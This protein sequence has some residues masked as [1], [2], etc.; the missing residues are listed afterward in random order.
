MK[1]AVCRFIAFLL[2]AI[3]LVVTSG[4]GII[5]IQTAMM[6]PTEEVK[7]NR[8]DA[9][10]KTV[11][12]FVNKYGIVTEEEIQPFKDGNYGY[13]D[14]D[15]ADFHKDISGVMD[16]VTVDITG[17][18]ENE[19]F[20]VWYDEGVRASV[21]EYKNGK[22]VPVWT[23]NVG[24]IFTIF[25]L[26]VYKK[27]DKVLWS[28]GVT[29]HYIDDMVS[30]VDGEYKGAFENGYD[31][32]EDERDYINEK[33]MNFGLMG[34]GEA[35]IEVAS[36]RLGVTYNDDSVP[37]LYFSFEGFD[38]PATPNDFATRWGIKIPKPKVTARELL[39]KLPYF[40]DRSKCK[41]SKEMA[42][43]YAKTISD[44]KNKYDEASDYAFY[45]Y[46]ADPAGDGM[47]ILITAF[48]KIDTY[49]GMVVAYSGAEQ[50]MFDVW[51][52]DGKKVNN[53]D[54]EKHNALG[55][56]ACGIE[57]STN[58][59]KPVVSLHFN[60][61]SGTDEGVRGN[62]YYS[63]ENGKMSVLHTEI[64]CAA[65]GYG[66]DTMYGYYIPL[67]DGSVYGEMVGKNDGIP[68]ET[69]IAN[70][71]TVSGAG[72][73]G[74]SAVGS[75]WLVDGKLAKTTE[76]PEGRNLISDPHSQIMGGYP[77]YQLY[78]WVDANITAELLAEYSSVAGRPSYSYAEA[79]HMISDEQI[80]ALAEE[81]AKSL[82]GEIGD[83]YKLADDLYYIVIYVGGKPCGG[84]VVKNTE[85]GTGWRTIK[86]SETVLTEAELQ[87][88]VNDEQ[89]VSNVT[90]DF[91][92]TE[93]GVEQLKNVFANIDGTVPNDAAKSDISSY[94]EACISSGS[95]VSVKT[96]GNGAEITKAVFDECRKKAEDKRKELI[97]VV[98][99]NGVSL[100]KEIT[101]IIRIVCLD[102][103][104]KNPAKI[105]LDSDIL[106]SIGDVDSVKLIIGDE[107]HAITISVDTLRRYFADYGKKL[108]ITIEKISN[109]TYSVSFSDVTGNFLQ[110]L[111]GGIT[112]T[113][114]ADNEFCTVLAEYS[115]ETR[116]WGGQFDETNNTISFETPYPGKYSVVEG[117]SQISDIDGLPAEK[118]K[119]IRFMVSKGY[120]EAENKLFNP[121]ATLT[122]YDFAMALVRMFF[123]LDTTLTCGFSDVPAD[124]PYYP[125]VASGTAIKVIEGY[126]D[127]TFKGDKNVL[128]EEVLALCSRT[129]REQKGYI[130]PEDPSEY[131]HFEDADAIPEWARPE[132]ALAVRETLISEGGILNPSEEITRAEAAEI[133]YRLFML[134]YETT[135]TA[136]A[137]PTTPAEPAAPASNP[138]P[139]ILGASG[140][141]VA[142]AGGAT[143]F[144]LIRRKKRKAPKPDTKGKTE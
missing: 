68:A 78:D 120:F 101:V 129:L 64:N 29:R 83:I 110:K 56:K 7:L 15:V 11:Q 6:G 55:R 28:Y 90:I 48:V 61:M 104:M 38:L 143:A 89:A 128:R 125:Y 77:V 10:R 17:D 108:I 109:G 30:Y 144:A 40:G 62:V 88:I 18:G 132:I 13:D 20:C 27:S 35:I 137:A 122:R 133:L 81:I 94:I 87:K 34:E 24:D 118:Q 92:N 63:I 43:A 103:D 119:A 69:L 74:V 80:K 121:D 142:L 60:S 75:V 67:A 23:E 99:E 96:D 76:W 42:E 4:C 126:P 115:S 36:Q 47:P 127:G 138:L 46:L 14:E 71:W 130:E 105:T 107:T 66:G 102:V 123:A 53:V 52:Y 95:T 86:S 116:N 57:F 139:I 16:A 8:D 31:F 9:F 49:N 134:L 1:K 37:V 21:F 25:H 106:D 5:G 2:S 140:G 100:N 32:T 33:A 59:G 131:L 50:P 91:K 45:A 51:T 44:V 3:L 39:E 113:L 135:P 112:F 58:N 98:T 79:S 82:D 124:S 65:R 85:N 73:I 22:A 19:L 136:K 70:G 72:E 117:S 97:G 26:S 141:A 111:E 12:D 114:P 54:V 41:M 84:V 93:N